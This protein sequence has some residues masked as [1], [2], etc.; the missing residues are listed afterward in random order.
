[1]GT[2]ARRRADITFKP[3]GAA[4]GTWQAAGAEPT[5]GTTSAMTTTSSLYLHQ[6]LLKNA[7]NWTLDTE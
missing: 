1:M 2:L 4:L 6:N 5:S 7:I 3:R